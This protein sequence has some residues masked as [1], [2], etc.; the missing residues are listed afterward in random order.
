[1]SK[2]GKCL[3]GQVNLSYTSEPQMFFIC[4]CTNCQGSTGSPLASIIVVPESDFHAEGVT[5]SY[6]CDAKVTRSFCPNCG[7]QMFSRIA[8][9][10]GI[11]AIKTGI[12]DEQPDMQP[13]FSCWTQSKP[14]WFDLVSP[15]LSFKQNPG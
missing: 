13:Q 5:S 1:M 9:A 4:H 11:V 7:S 15:E 2:T 10:P 6:E 12:L 14:E 8:S 3:C